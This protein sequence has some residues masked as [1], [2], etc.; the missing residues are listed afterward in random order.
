MTF[1][2][3]E[4]AGTCKL[5]R[6]AGSYNATSR[7]LVLDEVSTECPSFILDGHYEGRVDPQGRAMD[8]VWS[9][10]EADDVDGSAGTMSLT[11]IESE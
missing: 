11:K 1:A 3:T 2:A 9:L 8:L 10:D 6:V 5:V 7:K 4:S